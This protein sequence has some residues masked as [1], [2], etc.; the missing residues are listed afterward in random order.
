LPD[1][2]QLDRVAVEKVFETGTHQADVLI[3]LFKMVYPNGLFDQIEKING[4][5][6]CSRETSLWFARAFAKFDH[7]HHPNTLPG[8]IWLNSGF[9]FS[10]PEAETLP[11]LAVIPAPYT[12]K[13]VDE[14]FEEPAAEPAEV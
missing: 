14:R 10:F 5:P 12:P 6:I 7:Q 2:I 8:G 11:F 3:E 1:P 4:F 9:S 13:P